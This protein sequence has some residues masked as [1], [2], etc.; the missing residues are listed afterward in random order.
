M[1]HEIRTPL[2]AIVG[3]SDL[4]CELQDDDLPSKKLYADHINQNSESLLKL[5]NNILSI[6]KIQEKMIVPC[7]RSF[8]VQDM[9]N[10]LVTGYSFPNA[11]LVKKGLHFELQSD[12]PG[13]AC[14]VETDPD[15]LKQILINLL[16][17]AVKYTMEGSIHLIASLTNN[18]LRIAVKDTGIGIAADKLP[19]IF[20]RFKRLE[21]PEE[22]PN[23]FGLGLSICHGLAQAIGS[24]IQ[25]ESSP[26][27]GSCFSI[28]LQAI[29]VG[30]RMSVVGRQ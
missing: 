1:S 16:D 20:D 30:N 22:V 5:I 26:G 12:L 15:F 27:K 6:S 21:I 7:I 11:A 29:S 18:Q 23:G 28:Q 4:L 14:Q 8:D 17:N 24:E 19:H 9:L 10:D 2:N 25:V 13:Q 3:F